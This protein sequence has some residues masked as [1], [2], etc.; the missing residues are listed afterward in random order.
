MTV[1][2]PVLIEI[3]LSLL[4]AEAV[5]ARGLVLG[6][7]LLTHPCSP[8]YAPDKCGKG[9]LDRLWNESILVLYTL[10]PLAGRNATVLAP[11]ATVICRLHEAQH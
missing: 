3:I 7:R 11:M 10:R 5:E 6:W 9:D 1:A 2:K 8:L 4:S